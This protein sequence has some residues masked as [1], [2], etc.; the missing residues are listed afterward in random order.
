MELENIVRQIKPCTMDELMIK[1]EK[2]IELYKEN[3][4]CLLDVRMDFEQDIWALS[5][6]KHIQ[7][8]DVP[9]RLTELPKDKLIVVACPT[10]NR[11]STVSAYLK[12]K[13]FNSKFLGEGL[14]N[15]MGQLKGK[16]AKEL[17]TL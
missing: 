8:P 5:I 9:D 17:R 11:S 16:T 6:A 10:L 12:T 3:K 15:L 7:A 2:F 14:V 1:N 4:V 13:G